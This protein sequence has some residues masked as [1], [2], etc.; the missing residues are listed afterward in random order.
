MQV[1]TRGWQRCRSCPRRH[2]TPRRGPVHFGVD[3]HPLPVGGHQLD[4][5]EVVDGQA[6]LA[7]EMPEP[8]AQRQAADAGVAD[9]AAGGGQPV[10]LGGTVELTPEHSASRAHGAGH[11]VDSIAFISERSIITPPSQTA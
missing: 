7:H 6:V 11:R 2:A 10:P 8:T 9:D 5:A 3:V 1:D 4:G